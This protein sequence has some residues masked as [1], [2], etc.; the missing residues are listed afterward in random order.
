MLTQIYAVLTWIYGSNTH[1][2]GMSKCLCYKGRNHPP[3][4]TPPFLIGL[5]S[6]CYGGLPFFT[7]Q[8]NFRFVQIKPCRKQFQSGSNDKI[9]SLWLENTFGIVGKGENC[10]SCT[11]FSKCFTT[12]FR[13]T[14]LCYYRKLRYW[15]SSRSLPVTKL[16][17]K[18]CLHFA[19]FHVKSR[20]TLS[21]AF[22]CSIL[23][24]G[25]FAIN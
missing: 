4:P 5:N 21:M 8:Q 6:R 10:W 23:K 9:V 18:C 19:P 17:R 20:I 24:T 25:L 22:N 3:P 16:V 14:K 15:G 13:V 1:S 11:P 7:K 12:L 2:V